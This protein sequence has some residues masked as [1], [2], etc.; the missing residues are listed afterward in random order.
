MIRAILLDLDD[1]LYGYRVCNN[2]ASKKVIFALSKKY[3]VGKKRAEKIYESARSQI[4][5]NTKGQAASHSRLLYIKRAVEIFE[6]RTNV[7]FTL[8]LER[9]FWRAYFSKM[10]ITKEMKKFLSGCKRAGLKVAIVTNLTTQIQLE[11]CLSLGIAHLVDFVIT[12]EEAGRE[13]P[14]GRI[15]KLALK[16]LGCKRGDVVFVGDLDDRACA[17]KSGLKFVFG[18]N[19]RA[20]GNILQNIGV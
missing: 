11:K 9:Q 4:K 20:L 2:F 3:G 19:K 8:G 16:R 1:T 12:S 14:D 18:A 17:K 5:A 7:K 15:I 13:K 6:G 10:K